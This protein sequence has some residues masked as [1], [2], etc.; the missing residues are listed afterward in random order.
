MERYKIITLVDI[1]RTRPGRANRDVKQHNQQSNFNSLLQAIHLRTNITSDWD[2][3]MN[4]GRFPD[5]WEGKGTYWVY[6]F[7]AEREEVFFD[8]STKDPKGL[9]VKDLDGVPIV[10]NLD[11]TVEFKLPVFKTTGPDFNT[12]IEI[13]V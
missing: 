11:N 13:I 4:T 8:I 7:E 12:V 9:L 3:K 10:D 6:E 5:H 1:T 2:P